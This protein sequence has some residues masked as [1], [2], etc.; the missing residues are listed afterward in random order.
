MLITLIGASAPVFW[1]GLLLSYLFSI[2]LGWLPAMG[3]TSITGDAAP[4][5]VLRHLIL[6]AFAN[7]IISM[8]V[9]A[10]IVRSNM[11]ETLVQPYILAA[12]ARGLSWTR[13]VL[14]HAFRNV[15][16]DAINIAGL[17]VGFLFGGALFVEVVFAWPGIGYLI[18]SSIQARDYVTL[19]ASVLVVSAV[20]VLVNLVADMAR[21]ALDPRERAA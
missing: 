3:M 14:V 13:Q 10:R 16:P 20:F 19:Q 15:L 7:S 17:Q 9:I 1:I 2:R 21:M 18:Y 6:P 5:I 12:R 11:L 8:A 4:M